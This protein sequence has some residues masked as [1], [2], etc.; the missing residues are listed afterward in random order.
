MAE[1]NAGAIWWRPDVDATPTV[2]ASE[3]ARS[4]AFGGLVVFTVILLLSPQTF[5]PVLKTVRIALLA[6]GVAIAAHAM[7]ST[8]RRQPIMP[9]GVEAALTVALLVWTVLTIPLSYWPSGSVAVL[10]DQYIKALVFFWMIATL[11]TNRERLRIFAWSL[12][13]CSIPLAVMALVHY[14][15]GDFLST[16]T[17]LKRIDGYAGLSGNPNDLALCLNLL[18]PITAALLITS[19]SWVG[20]GF[21][22]VSLLL[23]VPAVIITFSR[24]G[25]LTLLAIVVMGTIC[26]M[27]RGAVFPAIAV[28]VAALCVPPILPD[29]YVERLTTIVDID[30]DATGSAQG[31][32]TDYQVATQVILANPI[33]GVG[34][35]QDILALNEARG[36]ATWRSVHNAFLEYAVDLGIP[37]LL[38]FVWLLFASLGSARRVERFT[39]RVG[40][41]WDLSVFAAGAQVALI[42]FAV[43]AF[44]HPIAYQFY[45]FCVAGLAVA[46][47]N[48]GRT[49]AQMLRSQVAA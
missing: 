14:A 16:G 3:Q 34:L 26:F 12:S 22:M 35:G 27:R 46:L 30:A 18:I 1:I 9:S 8:V 19:R 39:R 10:T 29:G 11:I 6:A 48:V 15:S 36:H 17:S 49:E 40:P 37:G 33:V 24:A 44:F 38:L 47:K 28:V 23:S 43:A 21:A 32:W 45:F 42:A 2:D 20:R 13:V 25:F 31:R 4:L 41:L 5:F 7:D